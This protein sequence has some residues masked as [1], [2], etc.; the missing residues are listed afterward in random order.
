MHVNSGLNENITQKC[1]AYF[2]YFQFK[3]LKLNN[4]TLKL[5]LYLYQY[6]TKRFELNQKGVQIYC[7]AVPKIPQTLRYCQSPFRVILLSFYPTNM[8]VV[9]TQI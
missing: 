2:Q 3:W 4:S 5:D 6:D 1:T 8:L 7:I 9:L